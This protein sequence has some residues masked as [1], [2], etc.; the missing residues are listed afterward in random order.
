M[1]NIILVLTTVTLCPIFVFL[2]VNVIKNN[3]VV[4]SLELK[5]ASLESD[6]LELKKQVTELQTINSKN[7]SKTAIHEDKETI[8]AE[9]EF[10]E[11]LGTYKNKTDPAFYICNK[12][13]DDNPPNI[14]KLQAETL[15]YTCTKCN[16]YYQTEQQRSA[17]FK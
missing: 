8:L 3:G 4:T 6:N 12:C 15:G 5:I 16:T 9:Y 14:K 13:I 1:T 2:I 7:E 11:S 10:D 17:L